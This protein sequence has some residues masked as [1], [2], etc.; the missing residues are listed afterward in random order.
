MHTLIYYWLLIFLVNIWNSYFFPW[1]SHL[2]FHYVE[3]KIWLF[4]CVHES[5]SRAKQMCTQLP[6]LLWIKAVCK[7]L[8]SRLRCFK[9]ASVVGFW[10]QGKGNK[11]HRLQVICKG[12]TLK[13]VL[14]PLLSGWMVH[15]PLYLLHTDSPW[16]SLNWCRIQN[17]YKEE[18]KDWRSSRRR[19]VRVEDS[20]QKLWNL[21]HGH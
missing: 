14:S 3:C 2:A 8:Q 4:P 15:L 5:Q 9:S 17:A 12:T 19:K 13:T 16:K 11:C 7:R 1:S 20:W 10:L 6:V 21:T 18:E